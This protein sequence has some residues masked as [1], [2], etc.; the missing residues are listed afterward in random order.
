MNWFVNGVKN[1][2]KTQ[3]LEDYTVEQPSFLQGTSNYECPTNALE[4]GRWI[5]NKCI[6]CRG[7]DLTATGKQNI[8]TVNTEL[9]NMFKKS[10]YLYPID[11]GTCGACNVEFTTLFSPQYDTNRFKIFMSNTP[12]HADALVVMGVYTR[13]ME[14]VLK[15][16][17]EA[18]PAPKVVIGIGACA[19]SGGIIGTSAMEKYDI[20]VAGCPPTPASV[21]KA[22]IKARG[23]K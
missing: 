19:L 10:L 15:E 6:F 17:Y 12:R 20:E 21:I 7:C 16:A 5:M 13:G 22:I 9:P 2:I 1:R 11:S 23:V 3:G 8:F 4:N 18:M 14:K